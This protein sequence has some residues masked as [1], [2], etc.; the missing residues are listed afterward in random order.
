MK[1]RAPA[2]EATLDVACNPDRSMMYL[3]GIVLWLLLL[4]EEERCGMK[5]IDDN[6]Q[7]VV[8]SSHT[9]LRRILMIVRWRFV[10]MNG[11]DAFR[12]R[13]QNGAG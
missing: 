2:R 13:K 4:C 1:R 6:M 12:R 5:E 8:F 11:E 9:R 7:I 3:F 10:A